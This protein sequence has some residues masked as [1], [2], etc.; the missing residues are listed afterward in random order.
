VLRAAHDISHPL[1]KKARGTKHY[2]QLKSNKKNLVGFFGTFLGRGRDM[3]LNTMP[4]G[5]NASA[6]ALQSQIT[7]MAL[8]MHL[9]FMQWHCNANFIA[10]YTQPPWHWRNA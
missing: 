8:G 9:Y 10:H 3:A 4:N 2:A 1:P 5:I 7:A 6:M